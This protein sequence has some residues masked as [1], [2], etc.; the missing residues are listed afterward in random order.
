VWQTLPDIKIVKIGYVILAILLAF[1]YIFGVIFQSF[2]PLGVARVIE[3]VGSMWFIFLIYA[4]I[5]VVLIDIVRLFDHWLH[6][7]PT[8][9]SFGIFNLQQIAA[10]CVLVV[11]TTLF[12]A[13]YYRFTHPKTETLD[14]YIP[15]KSPNKEGVLNIAVASDLHLGS[16]IRKKTTQRFVETINNLNSDIILLVGD[17]INSDLRTLKEQE[18]N[19]YLK[20]LDAPLGVYSVLGNHEYISRD[21]NEAMKFL[22]SADIEVLKDDA[23]VVN[24]QI[25]L[26]GRDDRTNHDRKSLKTLVDQIDNYNNLPIIVMDHQPYNLNEVIDG[27]ITLSLSGHTHNGQ[28]WPG[29]LIVRSMYE[30]PY[31]YMKKGNSHF[32]VSSGLG[33]WGPPFR[34]GTQSEVVLIRMHFEK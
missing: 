23:I 27:N 30:L 20:E 5:S 6:V 2:I 32:Y 26:I 19:I 33:L 17:V 16:I 11:I 12:I 14:I 9:K 25:I 4:L 24:H 34:I 18:L 21:V 7:L 29:N 3:Y 8:G 15:Q 1:G 10:L 31:G 13:G 28:I 22:R